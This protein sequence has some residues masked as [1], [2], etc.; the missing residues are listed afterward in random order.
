MHLNSNFYSKPFI[1]EWKPDGGSDKL[2]NPG[3]IMF[4]N[5]K[6]TEII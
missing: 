4:S 6:I 1:T 3:T 2:L 5:H